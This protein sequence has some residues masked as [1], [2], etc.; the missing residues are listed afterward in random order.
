MCT[1]S[2]MKLEWSPPKTFKKPLFLPCKWTNV[3]KDVCSIEQTSLRTFVHLH[4]K[5]KGFLKVFGGLH[6]NFIHECVHIVHF[7]ADVC[8][9]TTFSKKRA[10]VLKDVCSNLQFEQTSLRTF[11]QIYNLSKRP[12]WFLQI[13]GLLEKRH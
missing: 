6:S 8:F 9:S 13:S 4:G 5:N 3:L 11:V 7:P 12:F 10:N 1:H 2:W